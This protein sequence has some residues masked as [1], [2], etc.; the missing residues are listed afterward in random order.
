L[1][2][3]PGVDGAEI[4]RELRIRK[5]K[6][7]T[8]LIPLSSKDSKQNIVKG[9]ESGADDYLIKPFDAE[10]LQARYGSLRCQ[11]RGPQTR[12]H[13]PAGVCR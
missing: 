6:P 9:L 1:Q 10:E 5:N 2:Q 7:Y 4:C 12:P 11:S 13:R 8:Y 3:P